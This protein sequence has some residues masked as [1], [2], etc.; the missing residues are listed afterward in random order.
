MKKIGLLGGTEPE[1]TLMYYKELNARID[2]MTNGR[3]M[4]E[5]SIESADIH[6]QKIIDLAMEQEF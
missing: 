1:S 3:E 5:L 6:M 4:P 2:K